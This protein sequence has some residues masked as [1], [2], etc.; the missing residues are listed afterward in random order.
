MERFV[1]TVY[2]RQAPASGGLRLALISDL[3]EREC[4]TPLELL[5]EGKPDAILI[6]GDTL[7]HRDLWGEVK[8]VRSLPVRIVCAL[9]GWMEGILLAVFGR[10]ERC[11]E[12]S[13]RFLEEAVKIA[14]V[15][16]SV[17]NHEW[18]F[19][20]EELEFFKKKGIRALDNAHCEAVI[21]DTRML[22]GGL[23]PLEDK[24]WLDEFASLARERKDAVSVLLCHY[25]DHYDRFIKKTERDV[26][27]LI[28][29]GHCHGGQW[30]IFGRGVLSP[31][32]GLFSKRSRG[33][34]PTRGGVHIVGAGCSNTTRIPRFGNPCEVVFI[35]LEG[36]K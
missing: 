3:H 18:W 14:P 26:F 5:R 30:R 32:L 31:G 8:E 27:D 34:F 23:S 22:I 19:L 9:Y 4:D 7:E 28:L 11:R 33:M 13:I 2:Q 1:T 24:D 15:Y 6:A 20:P 25:P 17:G 16:I 36:R 21:R 10:S 35:D 29:S 12:N